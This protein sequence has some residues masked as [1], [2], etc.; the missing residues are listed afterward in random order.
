[1]KGKEIAK[2]F[3]GFA[4]NQVLTHGEVDDPCSGA[5]EPRAAV[6][7]ALIDVSAAVGLG[8]RSCQ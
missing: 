8:R 5:V 1:M 7:M 2:F 3:A 4:A 6:M